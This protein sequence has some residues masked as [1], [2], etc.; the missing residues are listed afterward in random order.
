[1]VLFN[2]MIDHQKF[3]DPKNVVH[4]REYMPQDSTELHE[5]ASILFR[6]PRSAVLGLPWRWHPAR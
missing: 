2:P 3:H 6:H 4:C 1:L 5:R